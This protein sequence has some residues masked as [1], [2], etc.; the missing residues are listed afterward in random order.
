VPEKLDGL[1]LAG[2]NISGTHKAH[3]NF[4]VMTICADVGYGA[5]TAAALAA[6]AGV[7][8]RDADVAAVQRVLRAAGFE[9]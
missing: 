6:K 9:P 7:R 3:S 5:G 4:R 8:P 2:R 1:L